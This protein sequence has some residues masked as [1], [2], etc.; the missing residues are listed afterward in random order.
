ML[1][2]L[3][4]FVFAALGVGVLSFVRYGGGIKEFVS[5]YT[6]TIVFIILAITTFILYYLK[7]EFMAGVGIIADV[8]AYINDASWNSHDRDEP[9]TWLERVFNLSVPAVATNANPRGYWLRQRIHARLC[10]LVETLLRDEKPERLCIV[11]HSQGTMIAIDM[12]DDKGSLWLQSMR[13]A[14]AVRKEAGQPVLDPQISLV[15]MGSPYTHLYNYY[16]PHSFAPAGERPKLRKRE[17]PGSVGFLTDWLNIYRINDFVG[18]FIGPGQ[19]P[20]ELP[21]A[22]NGHTNYWVDRTVVSELQ[23]FLKLRESAFAASAA[24]VARIPRDHPYIQ[25]MNI[26]AAVPEGKPPRASLTMPVGGMTCATCAGSVE[27]A[28]ARIPG[29]EAQVNLSA[30]T[31]QVSFDPSRT[32]ARAL[33]TAVLEAGYDVPHEHVELAVSGMTCATCA[34]RVER[35]LEA[36]PG[37]IGASVNLAGERP[38]S[39]SSAARRPWRRLSRRWRMRAMR[40]APSPATPSAPPPL[41]AKKPRNSDGICCRSL[42]RWRSPRR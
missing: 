29:V 31:A 39:R 12:L 24:R 1:W 38:M 8:L 25:L 2:I 16:F 40:R 20:H 33:E 32:D 6:L 23:K 17:E 35:A 10:V 7:A 42:P 15:T 5:N 14:T 27:K 36:A 11:S 3:I 28:L 13:A 26:R 4:G 19:W 41:S 18:T 37:V 21:V 9:R 22:P 30:E 34:G